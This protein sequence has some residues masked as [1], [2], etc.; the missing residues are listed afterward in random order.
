[1]IKAEVPM[2]NRA[3]RQFTPNVPVFSVN[4]NLT[5]AR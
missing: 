1:M 4:G 5:T 3:S 2:A